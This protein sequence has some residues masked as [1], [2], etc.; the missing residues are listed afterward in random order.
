MKTFGLPATQTLVSLPS[1]DNGNTITDSLR[2]HDAG[3]DWTPPVVVPLV[4]IDKPAEPSGKVAEPKLVWFE[5]RVERQWELVDL[6]PAALRE[7]ARAAL[8]A[9]WA[10]QPSWIRGPFDGHFRGAQVF[11]DAG[12]DDAAADLIRYAEAPG[13]YTTEQLA[14]FVTLKTTIANAIAALPSL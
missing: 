9:S 2:P 14:T 3:D 10:A 11:L 12:D 8:R 4:K 6:S 7:S 1:D 13:A 5:D